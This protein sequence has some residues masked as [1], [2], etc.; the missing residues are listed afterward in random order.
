MT[1][2][3]RRAPIVLALLLPVVAFL[4]IGRTV[5]ITKEAADLPSPEQGDDTEIIEMA[6]RA[7]GGE[8][9]RKLGLAGS[10]TAGAGISEFAPSPFEQ[11]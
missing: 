9:L 1:R 4:V 8:V 2:P 3:L 7:I 11:I 10:G 6:G 5:E